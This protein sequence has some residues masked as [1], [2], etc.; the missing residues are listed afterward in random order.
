MSSQDPK[1]LIYWSDDGG[2]TWSNP[3]EVSVG[4]IGGYNRLCRIF[5]L[6]QGRNR[7]WKITY[8]EP[9]YFSL[10]G[11]IIDVNSSKD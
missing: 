2:Y 9:T 5:K 1:M 6:G 8:R 3:R 7:L 10:F 11:A 4:G